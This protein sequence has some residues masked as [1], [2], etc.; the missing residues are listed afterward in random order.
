MCR[1][2]EEANKEPSSSKLL[3]YG[4]RDCRALD[5]SLPSGESF[6]LWI[7]GEFYD[8]YCLSFKGLPRRKGNRFLPRSRSTQGMKER[9]QKRDDYT[10]TFKTIFKL[11]DL[12]LTSS[13]NML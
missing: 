10:L 7:S 9:K 6:L 2:S 1:N 13:S 4:K 8:E 3:N 12:V 5:D 11:V